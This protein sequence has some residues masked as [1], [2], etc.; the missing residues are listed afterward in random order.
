MHCAVV[1]G[2][3]Y[4]TLEQGVKKYYRHRLRPVELFTVQRSVQDFN[5]FQT[6]H[7]TI[8]VVVLVICRPREKQLG[9]KHSDSESE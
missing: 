5:S 7:L 8:S 2:A 4:I 3:H 1:M 9:L 6:L